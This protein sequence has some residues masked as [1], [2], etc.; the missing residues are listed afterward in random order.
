MAVIVIAIM[1][2]GAKNLS[3]AWSYARDRMA[4]TALCLIL[5]VGV[6]A[7]MLEPNVLIGSFQLTALWWAAAGAALGMW[8]R[9]AEDEVGGDETPEAE[10][11][12]AA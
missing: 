10:P 12:A 3:V 6:I 9:N 5:V 8:S 1:R 2:I 4:A 7:T 11:E